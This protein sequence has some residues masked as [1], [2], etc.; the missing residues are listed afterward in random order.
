MTNYCEYRIKGAV[1]SCELLVETGRHENTAFVQHD[2]QYGFYV[3]ADKVEEVC[4]ALREA[5][6]LPPVWT[7]EKREHDE[8]MLASSAR[9]L[10]RAIEDHGEF[11][12]DGLRLA[13][14]RVLAAADEAEAR[15]N[16]PKLP[17]AK[18]SV[19]QVGDDVWVRGA[20]L[21]Q[22]PGRRFVDDGE[23]LAT[24]DF[25]VLYDPEKAS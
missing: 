24:L 25:D 13:A 17:T 6:G 2:D 15:A 4:A 18:N 5:A 16:R 11:H 22:V 8:P 3:P 12:P 14:A 19:I 20:E 10:T 7:V 9:A 1:G 23:W 21:W